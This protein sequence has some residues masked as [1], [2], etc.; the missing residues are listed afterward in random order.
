MAL[1]HAELTATCNSLGCAGPDKYCIDPQCSEAIR[2]L[3]KFLRRD[4]DDHEI[5]RFL[6]AANIVETDLLP[7][8]VE[9]SDKSELFDLVIRL[10]VNLTTPALLIYNEQPPMEKT[11]RQYYLQMLLHLQKYKRAFTD[12]N[13]WKVIVDKLAA[14]IQAE[15]YEKGEEKVL[16]TVRLLILV[17][18]ILHVPADN[19]AECRPDN[20]A[21]L[22]DQVLWA[23]H[24]SQLIDIIMYITCSDNEQQYYLH[25]L[26]IIS[27]MLRDQNATELANA[28]VNRSQTEKQ[29]DEQ[30]LKLVLEK[31]RKEKMEK[32][33]KYSGKRHSRFGGRFVVS[34]MKSIGDNE[35]VVSSMTSNINKAFDRY[36]KPLKTPR[37]R[38]PLKD[39]GIERKSAFSVRLFLKEFCVEFL[40]GAYNTLMKH[41]RETLVRSKGQPNDESY[42]FWAIQFFMEFNRNYKF[43]IKLVSETLALNIFHFI[44]ERIEDSREK[45]ITDKKKIPIW[46]KRM[47]LGLKAY[48]ELMETLLLMYQSKDPTLQSS[49]RTIL[50]NLFYMVEYRDL[51]LSLI[52]LYDE[53]KFSHMYLK[54][55]IETNHVFMK[56]L[57]HIGKK[58]RN[59]IVLCKAKTK[60]SKKSKSLPHNTPEDDDTLWNNLS[61]GLKEIIEIPD[62]I[63]DATE[64]K[65]Y[66]PISEVPMEDQKVESMR[67]IRI[68]IRDK[69][70]E[71]AVKLLRASREIWPED[72][73]FGKPGLN[74]DEELDILKQIF[75]ADLGT[76]IGYNENREESNDRHDNENNEI[77][78]EEEDDDDNSCQI[79]MREENF[80]FLDFVKKFAKP[81]VLQSCCQL[82]KQFENNSTY[83]NHAVV[84]LLHRI[85]YD[86]KYSA[87][88]FQASVFRVFQKIFLSKNPSHKELKNFAVFIMRKFTEVAQKNK[89]V[90]MELLFWKELKVAYEI[91]EG[92]N[93]VQNNKTT[94]WTEE[95]EDELHRLHEEYMRELPEEDEVTW[96]SKNL[97]KQD[98]S[99][100]SI[101]K[102]LKQL[103]IIIYKKQ[104][105]TNREF[106]EAEIVQITQL[107]ME[108]RESSDPIRFIMNKLDVKRPKKHIID[109]ILEL[110]LVGDRKELKKKKFKNTN[111]SND[112][113]SNS[114]DENYE[115]DDTTQVPHHSLTST[116]V[117]NAIKK[118][119]DK[120]LKP[121]LLWLIE[122][123]DDAAEDLDVD[124]SDIPL[125]PLTDECMT[126]V[127]DKDFQDAMQIL[128]IHKPSNIQE[129]YWRIPGTWQA[130]EL[131]QRSAAIKNV[132]EGNFVVDNDDNMHDKCDD[133]S[134]EDVEETFN[135]IRKSLVQNKVIDDRETTNESLINSSNV[136]KESNSTHGNNSKKNS[137]N[138]RRLS[139]YNSDKDGSDTEK[140]TVPM[141]TKKTFLKDSDEDDSDIE[142]MFV[143]IKKKK[144]LKISDEEDSDHEKI[145]VPKNN[146]ETFLK[147]NDEENNDIEKMFVPMKKKTILLEDSDEENSDTEKITI[148]KQICE[149]LEDRDEEIDDIDL[150]S[151]LDENITK[152]IDCDKRKPSLEN[153]DSEEEIGAL[154][155]KPKY[156]ISGDSD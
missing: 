62:L 94:N 93:A 117:L 150:E 3:I 142:K 71:D 52:N 6:G 2:D 22:H 84:R 46:S 77:D 146:K 126:A 124:E 20:D 63:I 88:M 108:F 23:M 107:V 55:L 49:A 38:M 132:I 57:E 151:Q 9:Y 83:T 118:L 5:R 64:A 1:V 144:I 37:N 10:L 68:L 60:V 16:S 35:M 25:T 82:L 123:L 153:T 98:R 119:I 15:Y 70:L 44:Q 21:N 138:K 72:S 135:R 73:Y 127:N 26:E 155:K 27:L 105:K 53:V 74:H 28:S 145:T 120:D 91:E 87:L 69:H 137:L 111:S 130:N 48:K 109:K 13:V 12:V 96:I 129:T 43:E 152:E 122:S 136:L 114:S 36:K 121:A 100:I 42:Y 11:P 33:K 51:I 40:Q 85:T 75:S 139:S 39:S 18:N 97:I 154:K 4:G 99:R 113:Q 80:E 103:D 24:Q 86:C 156:L 14:V 45:L 17:R 32:I 67:R 30:E 112:N 95:Q 134:D 102:K 58:Q 141:K 29:R 133:S 125:L 92:Y 76:P 78:D 106:T 101:I 47:H 128:G 147:D 110:G 19:D 8:L 90:F 31:E 59:L 66:D 143:P 7:I 79:R 54:D 65:P 148:K 34:G 116:Y 50:T 56:L 149:L 140:I 115:S 131:R 41:I 81:K 89:K 61:P 104:K